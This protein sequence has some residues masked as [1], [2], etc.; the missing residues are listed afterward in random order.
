ML[1]ASIKARTARCMQAEK[2]QK[3]RKE[4]KGSVEG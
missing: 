1:R 3:K 2:E 4:E